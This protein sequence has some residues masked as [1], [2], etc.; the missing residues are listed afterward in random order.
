MKPPRNKTPTKDN[1]FSRPGRESMQVVHQ[2]S[3]SEGLESSLP[4]VS[5]A[6]DSNKNGSFHN[7]K[8]SET[9]ES[10]NGAGPTNL[11]LPTS[12]GGA[13]LKESK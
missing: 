7:R 10:L 9:K 12:L 1:P 8:A 5:Q 11:I 2:R 4:H 13:A 3:P 6:Q